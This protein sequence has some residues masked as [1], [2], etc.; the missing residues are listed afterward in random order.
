M[1]PGEKKFEGLKD[2]YISNFKRTNG[3]HCEATAKYENGFVVLETKTSFSSGKG[4][5]RISE[6]ENMTLNLESRVDYVEPKKT[7]NL[8]KE[9]G[10]EVEISHQDIQNRIIEDI[11][12]MDMDN[13]I[14]L[15]EHMYPVKALDIDG[16]Y[17]G[18][19]VDESKGFTTLKEIF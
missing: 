13:F 10:K 18:L 12:E 2:R 6:F 4:K 7:D 8:S 9:E 14:A 15:I 3:N 1:T 11:K 17:I 16:E 19:M 5:H